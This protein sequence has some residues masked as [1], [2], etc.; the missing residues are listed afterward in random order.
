ML[1]IRA[2]KVENSSVDPGK[3]PTRHHSDKE[4]RL[5]VWLQ[6]HVESLASHA[7]YDAAVDKLFNCTQSTSHQKADRHLQIEQVNR[8]MSL[9]SY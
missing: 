2:N 8:V 9:F 1:E 3:Q 7:A 5:A 6:F 4:Q